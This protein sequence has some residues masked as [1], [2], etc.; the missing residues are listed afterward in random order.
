MKPRIYLAAAWA[1]KEEIRNIANE[2]IGQGED[3]HSRWLYEPTYSP[4]VTDRANFMRER[5]E[6]DVEDVRNADILVRF[7]DNLNSE[8]VPSGLATGAR[9]FETG[10]AYSLGKTIIVVGGY[11]CVFD[12]LR[13]VIHVK[14]VAELKTFLKGCIKARVV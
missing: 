9:M 8:T 3:V 5:A 1:R 14:D 13:T 11:Q 12:Y 2:L 4:Q 7:S 10:L 6:I